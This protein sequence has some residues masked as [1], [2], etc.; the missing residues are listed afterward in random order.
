MAGAPQHVL[1]TTDCNGN[2]VNDGCGVANINLTSGSTNVSCGSC[3]GT[4][5]ITTNGSCVG[6]GCTA[7]SLP[8][9][10]TMSCGSNNGTLDH[11]EWLAGRQEYLII[12]GGS[13]VT[14]ATVTVTDALGV[15]STY[16]F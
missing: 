15:S 13:S 10:I 7:S 2:D 3:T 8:D 4:M 6:S 1:R 16:A 12:D 11:T 14:G 9:V 5:T